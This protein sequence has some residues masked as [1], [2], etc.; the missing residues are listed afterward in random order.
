MG[1]RRGCLAVGLVRGS[2]CHYCLGGCSAL[3]VCARRSQQVRGVE[4]GAAACVFPVQS[5][6]PRVPRAACGG[7]FARVSL[8]L[9]RQYAIPCGLCVPWARSGCLSGTPSVPFAC[10]CTRA[11]A[12]SAPFCPPRIGVAR[13]P[14]VVPVQ[15]AGGA[16]PRGRCPSAFP[17]SVPCAVW[18][19]WGGGWP[20]P[21]PPVPGSGSCA[22]SWAGLGGGGGGGLCAAPPFFCTE[23]C[24]LWLARPGRKA[25]ARQAF[26]GRGGSPK[27]SSIAG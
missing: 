3:F 19:A 7:P 17:A 2:V 18:L 20:S 15:G 27:P 16:V 14:R 23:R 22:P 4:A 11:P 6:R 13:A 1:W 8:T 10:A 26:S 24:L 12:A 25:L 9:P 21:F 5:P